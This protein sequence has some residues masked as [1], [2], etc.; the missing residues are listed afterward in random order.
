MAEKNR[1]SSYPTGQGIQHRLMA[2]AGLALLV[3]TTLR[4]PAGG[5]DFLYGLLCLLFTALLVLFPLPLLED[6]VYLVHALALATGLLAGGAAAG[7]AC[8]LGILLGWLLRRLLS[9]RI[10]P[11]PALP[12][13][14]WSPVAGVIG[15]VLLPL[16]LT[17]LLTG[18]TSGAQNRL[19]FTSDPFSLLTPLLLF[20]L[21]HGGLY[22]FGA[23]SWRP[24]NPVS[25]QDLLSL[26]AFEIL[27]LPMVLASV[28][29]SPS[30]QTGSLLLLG[31]VAFLTAALIL[32]AVSIQINLQRRT[33]EAAT[34]LQ[35]SEALRSTL[36]LDEL[37]ETIQRQVTQ[38]LAVNNFYVAL[39]D[40]EAQSISY[41]LAVRA[42]QRDQWPSRP[43][44]N[45]LTDRVILEKKPLII[46]PRAHQQ[47]QVELAP[48]KVTPTAWIGVP[49]IAS[50]RSIGCLALFSVDESSAFTQNDLNLLLTLSGPI[51]VAIEN[52][53]LYEQAQRRAAQLE[54]L[55]QISR[56]I[57][58]SLEPQEVLD[59][60]CR[61]AALF[62]RSS[63]A[64]VF[65]LDSDSDQ[66]RLAHAHGLSPEFFRRTSSY[67]SAENGL[68]HCLQTGQPQLVSDITTAGL[69]QDFYAN[70][71]QEQV[72]AYGDFP[73]STPEGQIGFLSVYFDQPHHF[74]SEE[75]ELLQTFASQA[76]QAV[77]NARLYYTDLARSR[78]RLD[79]VINSVQE[80]ILM[81]SPD[82]SILV[83]NEAVHRLTGLPLAEL[84][85][86]N[87]TSLAPSILDI[88][89]LT[90]AQVQDLV[91]ALARGGYP[92]LPKVMLK[93]PSGSED[94]VLERSSLLVRGQ[95]GQVAGWMMVLRD[96][97]EEFRL[98]QAREFITET[99]VHDVRS[100]LGAV[101]GAIEMA[102]IELDPDNPD[103]SI[104]LEA[105]SV[106][107]RGA[108]RILG[109]VESLMDIAR[110][111]SGKMELNLAPVDFQQQASA[112]LAD[113]SQ[114]AAEFSLTLLNEIPNGLPKIKA[115]AE[116]LSRVLINMVDNAMKFT[117][118]GGLI[119]VSAEPL[120][121]E[122]LV[123]R[124]SDTG[125]GIPA[126]YREQIFERFSRV[127]VQ[128]TRRKGSGLG[129]NFCRL[130]V[131]AH[132][133]QIFVE[134]RPGG[135]S[136]FSF[137]IPFYR[138]N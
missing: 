81:T 17:L 30:I 10:S 102:Q 52:A 33:G 31:C 84:T 62:T 101:M 38:L 100:P 77:S 12:R 29:S 41:P 120:S 8:T 105:L 138:E 67:H 45:R 43:L 3:Y 35:V 113:F 135:G 119:S 19:Q 54:T 132:G 98:E 114:Q 2:A 47:V 22:L 130:A 127:P 20:A 133:G 115:D 96:I 42:G 37:L 51:S 36:D 75:I 48:S 32:Q 123:V 134:D 86:K 85:G 99:I 109:L 97:S 108:R 90:P 116:K 72:R 71:V 9:H 95:D 23:H 18:F 122:M 91:Q 1:P 69:D 15:R 57:S 28:L 94:Q 56:M 129:L 66:I 92:E 124:V 49:L 6:K 24:G 63:R 44:E 112:V 14:G 110:M 79:A 50:E 34:L 59:Q 55:N 89:G 137:T 11:L 87:L 83:V 46:N 40:A 26:A 88:F 65:L 13:S 118:E 74:S 39:Y 68:T 76:A 106:A 53:L 64:A 73:L 107:H 60:V 78:D 27:P 7:W 4:M 16:L 5:V 128:S 125:P 70:L 61:S 93:R 136:I 121:E 58:A 80:G 82:G 21:L 131:E 126:E 25:R 103:H 117:P 104:P 111:E